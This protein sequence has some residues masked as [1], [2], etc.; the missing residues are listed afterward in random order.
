MLH[1]FVIIGMHKYR[2]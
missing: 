2:G 1:S